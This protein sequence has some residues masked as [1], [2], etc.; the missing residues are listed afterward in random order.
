MGHISK[1]SMLIPIFWQFILQWQLFGVSHLL[2]HSPKY[3]PSA[4]SSWNSGWLGLPSQIHHMVSANHL[5]HI[6]PVILEKPKADP[7]S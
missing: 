4:Q 3:L 7:E 5:S 2:R 1:Q 6:T